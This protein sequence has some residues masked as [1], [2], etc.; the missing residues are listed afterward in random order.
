MEHLAIIKKYEREVEQVISDYKQ[1]V[2]NIRKLYKDEI[3]DEKVSDA[4]KKLRILAKQIEKRFITELE[5]HVNSNIDK[6]K[7]QEARQKAEE[8]AKRDRLFIEKEDNVLQAAI[9]EQVE[10][11]NNLLEIM[12]ILNSKDEDA[13]LS[14][15]DKHKGNKEMMNFIKLGADKTTGDRINKELQDIEYNSI[16]N[17]IQRLEANLRYE[18]ATNR[19]GNKVRQ[20]ITTTDNPYF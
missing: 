8:K 16:E 12:I 19:L 4:S 1:E 20:A 7:E 13:I 15:I 11:N 2:A 9:L 18:K 6:L 5:E 10:R 3:A 17:Q 14:L